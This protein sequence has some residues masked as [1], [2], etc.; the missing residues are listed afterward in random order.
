MKKK[1]KC[2]NH[3][4]KFLHSWRFCRDGVKPQ[5]SLHLLQGENVAVWCERIRRH[6]KLYFSLV[7]RNTYAH[8]AMTGDKLKLQASPLNPVSSNIFHI[9]KDFPNLKHAITPAY[10][11][12]PFCLVCLSWAKIFQFFITEKLDLRS[13][14]VYIITYL[15]CK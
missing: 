3:F 10:T 5:Q 1:L 4:I 2:R 14:A 12:S 13:H 11:L 15:A 8:W 7:L 9:N 6:I